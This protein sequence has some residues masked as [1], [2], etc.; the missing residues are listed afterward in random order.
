[1]LGAHDNAGSFGEAPAFKH[2]GTAKRLA[3]G[4]Q[5]GPFLIETL[6]GAGGMG[7]V[8]RAY[9]AKLQRAVAI[10]VLPDSFA[11]DPNR[12]ARFEE[13]ARALA[14]LNHP[15]VGSIYGLED[16]AGVTA[17]VLELVEG[18]TLG[19]RL[20]AGPLPFDEVLRVAR[21]MAEGLEAAH[22]RGIVH[23]DLK[24]E[25]LV[26]TDTGHVKILDFGLAHMLDDAE[27]APLTRTGAALGTPSYM[28]P[29]QIRGVPADQ[30]S[31]IF[32]L[33]VTLY[34][35]LTGSQ[36]GND[37]MVFHR[38][39]PGQADGVGKDDVIA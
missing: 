35:L 29:E 11:Q 16:S 32:S 1:M 39:V 34:Q 14:A 21:Q 5:L 7:E 30:R 12:L 20:A 22:E 38:D 15:Y 27:R 10:K 17:L 3:P 28:S 19:E 37:G 2:L 13:E 18:P 24:P 9:D 4:S 36:T 23:R 25:N 33:G 8:Y 26:L 6:I 31:D